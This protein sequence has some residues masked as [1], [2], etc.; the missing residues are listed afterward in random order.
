MNSAIDATAVLAGRVRGRYFRENFAQ[1]G[2]DLAQI[3][4]ELVTNA[5][6]AIAASGRT[7]GA[8]SVRFGPPDPAVVEAWGATVRKLGV[9]AIVDWR[10]ELTCQ[11]DGEGI[12]AATVDARLGALGVVSDGAG[13]RGLFGRG[14]RDVWLAQGGGRI[15]GVRDGRAV[16]S[17]FFPAAGDE[18]Y[19]YG[20]VLDT[21]AT[22][23]VRGRLAISGDGTCVT[24]PL[25]AARLPASARLRTLVAELV[26]LRPVL[27]DPE[28][29]V[30]LELPDRSVE[31]IAYSAPERDPERPTLFDDEVTIM[32][33][34]VARVV[35]HR[36]ADPIPLSSARA[37]RRGGLVIRS[38]RAA[39]E[40]TL[41]GLEGRAGARHLFGEVWCEAIERLQREALDSPRPEVVVRV[42]RGGLNDAHPLVHAAAVRLEAQTLRHV[43]H[44]RL[45]RAF[46]G[47]EVFDGVILSPTEGEAPSDDQLTLGD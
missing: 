28:R 29:E 6:A 15:H 17:W 12:D 31:R 40:A 1:A 30:Y 35:V 4:P 3:V 21:L 7:S 46:L 25:A 47:P 18:P 44:E 38:G 27:E 9:P 22:P 37:T 39:H 10:H 33:G 42:D 34:V 16:E 41:G 23:A 2:I 36:S 8:I 43:H 45:M 32:R 13:R 24:V 20:H 14:L 11:D 26:Q 5:D 19:L